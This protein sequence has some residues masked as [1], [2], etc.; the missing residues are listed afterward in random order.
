ILL[1]G[2]SPQGLHFRLPLAEIQL[3]Q[4]AHEYQPVEPAQ[5]SLN[6][7][8]VF[9]D[10]L[11]HGVLLLWSCLGNRNLT[12]NVLQEENARLWITDVAAE[13][14]WAGV[15]KITRGARA[16]V[17]AGRGA[18]ARGN[19]E[20]KA[21]AGNDAWK[22]GACGVDA[23]LSRRCDGPVHYAVGDSQADVLHATGRGESSPEL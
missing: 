2:G 3:V 19:G 10:K 6:L 18:E 15:R 21:R 13:P 20:G 4:C 23:P 14:H 16:G 12:D 17:R 22:S 7:V 11:L 5:R 1:H 8:F 9:R